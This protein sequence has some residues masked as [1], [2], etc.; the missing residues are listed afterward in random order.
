MVDPLSALLIAGAIAVVLVI[1]LRPERGLI[2]SWRRARRQGERVRIEDALKHMHGCEMR[3]ERFS[4]QSL[5]G[6]LQV[7]V[8]EASDLVFDMDNRGLLRMEAEGVRLTT[9]GRRS[10]LHILRAHR[11]WERYLADET[12]FG[13][14]DWHGQ[15]EQREHQLTPEE[16]DSLSA[17]LGNPTHDPHGDP[18]PT[19]EGDLVPHGGMPLVSA[20]LDVPLL[21]VHI[22]DEP[23][24]VYAQLVAEGLHPG[25]ELRLIE[26]SPQRV[27]FWSGEDEHL[28][29]PIVAAN[30]S[31]LQRAEQIQAE[32]TS[33]ERLSDL[34]PGEQARVLGISSQ[35]RG[36]ERRRLQDLG[37]LPGAEIQ[38]EFVSAGADP[39]AYRIREAVIA[40]RKDQA[41]QILIDSLEDRT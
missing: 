15:A 5:A 22:E 12:G 6:V 40:L 4:L 19:A 41:D 28:L 36:L 17:Q 37:F 1:L 2:P 38:A 32:L 27:R 24:A 33:G 18:I 35:C 39:V 10:A 7:S 31:V 14:L 16:A 29:A 11:L 9:V 26:S 34:R 25:M 13:E 21:V 23:N 20:S 8:D 3:G 30:I